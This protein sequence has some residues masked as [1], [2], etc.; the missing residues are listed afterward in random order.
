MAKKKSS[1]G[2]KPD[3]KKHKASGKNDDEFQKETDSRIFKQLQGAAQSPEE[4][5]VATV[6]QRTLLVESWHFRD[7]LYRELFG[8]P[9]YVVPD[10]YAPPPLLVEEEVV[11]ADNR[12]PKGETGDPGHPGLDEQHLNVLAY[13]PDPTRHYWTYVTAGLSSPWLQ[14]SP[15]EVSGFGCELMIKTKEDR[16][17]AV[18]ILRTMAFYIL[19]HAGTLSPGVRIDLNG[20][21]AVNTD[22]KLT[23]VF[24]WYPDEA[25]DCWYYLPSGGFGLFLAVGMTPD[26]RKFAESI[27]EY[28][29][30]C[31]Q[32]VLRQTGE[33]QITDPTRD[34]VMNHEDIGNI[35]MRVKIYADTFRENIAEPGQIVEG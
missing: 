19:N 12:E 4:E 11:L 14:D 9:A 32:Q 33:G 1:G 5:R 6:K 31:I 28:G 27:E 17:W 30:W 16:P 10:T 18:Q 15:A 13:P 8:E 34:T 25:P 29:T 24:I 23:N 7:D 20:P 2:D 22:S 35:M 26:E 21:I 3:P